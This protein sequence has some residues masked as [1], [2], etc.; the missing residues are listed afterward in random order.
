MRHLIVLPGNSYKNK[1][2]GELMLEHYA[3]QFDT[4]FMLE[5]DHWESGEKNIDFGREE[6]KLRVHVAAL[7]ANIEVVLMAKSVGSLLAFLSIY[8]GVIIPTRCL[9]FGIPFDLASPDMFKDSWAAVDTFKLP[10]LAFHNVEDPTTSYEFTKA[11]LAAHAPHIKLIATNEAD[12]WYGD[13]A[14][15]DS[16]IKE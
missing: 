11:T 1:T 8:H 5:Y 13:V 3:S 4:S 2:W 16:Y 14:N 9:F 12:H 7:P 10:A 15:Y 6:E